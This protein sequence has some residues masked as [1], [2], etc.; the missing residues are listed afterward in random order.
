MKPPLT[1]QIAR[2]RL[3]GRSGIRPINGVGT[4]CPQDRLEPPGTSRPHSAVL[5]RSYIAAILL[6][7]IASANAADSFCFTNIT[8]KSLALFEGTRPVFVYNHGILRAPGVPADRAR[9]S[10]VHP[11]YGLDGEVLSD[12]FPPDHYHH[13]GLFWAWPHVKVGDKSYDLWMLKGIEQRFEHWSARKAT[14][15]NAVLG[16]ENGWYIGAKKVMAEQVWFHISPA[17]DAGRNIDLDLIWKVGG[18]SITLQGAEGKSYGGLTLRFAPHTNI[19][20]TTPLGQREDDLSITRLPWADLSGHFKGYE[21]AIGA[22][23]FVAPDHP[24]YPPE[25]LT[26][27]YGVLCLGWPGVKSKTFQPGEI[28]RCRYRLWIHRGAADLKKLTATYQLYE[29]SLRAERPEE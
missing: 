23:I 2:K 26:R 11:L 27:H 18:Q 25:W 14:N 4:P 3:Q 9:S 17:T 13:R 5:A 29:Q 22:A 20:I 1:I 7:A 15:T 6:A 19:V 8:E 10:Y 24:D 16:I 28:I 12:D 21:K